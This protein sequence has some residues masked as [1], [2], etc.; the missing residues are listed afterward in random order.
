MAASE[1]E[2]G[3]IG[4]N[5]R[6]VGAA[7]TAQFLMVSVTFSA[8]GVFVIPLSEAFDTPRGRLNLGF[9]LGLP[10]FVVPVLYCAIKEASW[11]TRQVLS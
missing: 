2:I 11:K 5:D 4:G 1:V 8:F 7:F 3:E 9:S 10:I 6:V